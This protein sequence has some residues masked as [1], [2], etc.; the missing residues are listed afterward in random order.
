MKVMAWNMQ[1]AG[2][3]RDHSYKWT[4][5]AEFLNSDGG[6]DVDAVVIQE[7]GL[8]PH[9]LPGAHEVL[10]PVRG[11]G[12]NLERFIWTP[13]VAPG[14]PAAAGGDSA[15]DDDA[16][17]D[18]DSDESASESLR[19]AGAIPP[20]SYHVVFIRFHYGKRD[21]S[22]TNLAIL[23]RSTPIGLTNTV[24]NWRSLIGVG[25]SD[26]HR[27]IWLHCMHAKVFG[28]D[29]LDLITAALDNHY[30]DNHFII[31]DFNRPPDARDLLD[32]NLQRAAHGR[33]MLLL[34]PND[35]TWT[36]EDEDGNAIARV[37]DYGLAVGGTGFVG[38]STQ[39]MD[40][41]DHYAVIFTQ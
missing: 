25:I 35:Y 33:A 26:G 38:A 16:S 36:G 41:S 20:G 10:A 5:L 1:G 8:L 22:R 7:S 17:S 21:E 3:G 31:G 6:E 30:R 24:A 39:D 27:E 13:P 29:V 15:L 19:D 37:L 4:Q 40:C 11:D 23:T 12:W 2:K 34:N 32:P 9:R 28:G 14:A 18:G